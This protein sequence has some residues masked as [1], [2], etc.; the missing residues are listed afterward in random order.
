MD[1]SLGKKRKKKD[2]L[3]QKTAAVIYQAV[4]LDVFCL[5]GDANAASD[6]VELR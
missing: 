1:V 3:I 5:G 4:G 6:K 2:H